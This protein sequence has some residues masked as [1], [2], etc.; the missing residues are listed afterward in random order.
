MGVLTL[1]V[2]IMTIDALGT[3][4]NRVIAAYWEGLEDVALARYKLALLPPCPTIRVSSYSNCERSTHSFSKWI[5]RNL[6]L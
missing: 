6:A 5:F 1:K 2:L 4:L 3:L